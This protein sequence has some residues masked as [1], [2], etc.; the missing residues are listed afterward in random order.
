MGLFV[1]ITTFAYKKL[2]SAEFVC[3]GKGGNLFLLRIKINQ[4]H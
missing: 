2:L 3:F 1:I 4:K